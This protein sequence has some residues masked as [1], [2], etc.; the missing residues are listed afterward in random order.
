MSEL[1]GLGSGIKSG[2]KGLTGK[3]G[4]TLSRSSATPAHDVRCTRTRTR[5]RT[6]ANGRARQRVTQATQ[7]TPTTRATLTCHPP[8]RSRQASARRSPSLCAAWSSVPRPLLAR[9]P[10]LVR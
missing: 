2:T 8:P 9:V 1:K 6:Y 5:T 3:I 4:K 10:T 7:R